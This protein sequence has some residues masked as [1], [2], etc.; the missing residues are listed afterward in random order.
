[1]I[2]LDFDEELNNFEPLPEIE[3]VKMSIYDSEI[4]DLT[5]VMQRMLEAT[6]T[7]KR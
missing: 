5:D 6:R 7:D 2:M 4:C 3:E 1:M